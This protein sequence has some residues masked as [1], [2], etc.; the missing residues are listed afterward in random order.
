[1]SQKLTLMKNQIM[2]YDRYVGMN[3]KYGSV[4]IQT[5]KHV[6]VTF[7]FIEEKE[8]KNIFIWYLIIDSRAFANTINC[9]NIEEFIEKPD[10]KLS[11]TYYMWDGKGK[12]TADISQHKFLRKNEIYD[13]CENKLMLKAFEGISKRIIE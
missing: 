2:E 5:I 1:M 3:R 8:K 7:E 6:P 11:L 9:Q 13:C 4:R 10:G 12:E